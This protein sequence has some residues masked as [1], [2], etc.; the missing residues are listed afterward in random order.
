MTYRSDR[1]ITEELVPIKLLYTVVVNGADPDDPDVEAVRQLL[2][3]AA[4][5]ILAG[6]MPDKMVQISRR[7]ERIASAAEAPFRR[8][9]ARVAKFGLSVY[10]ALDQLRYQGMFAVPDGSPLEAA[11]E[12]LLH[13]DGSITEAANIDAVDAS[14]QKQGKHILTALQSEGLFRGAEWLAA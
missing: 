13:P 3:Q 8:A 5:D 1:Q 11:L 9:E 4:I 14:A 7:A 12:A 2:V 10:Y 6:L